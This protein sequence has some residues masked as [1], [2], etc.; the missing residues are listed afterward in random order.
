MK[1]SWVI[2]VVVGVLVIA[3]AGV[4]YAAFRVN[5]K[6]NEQD[7]A[8]EVVVASNKVDDELTKVWA[9]LDECDR[10]WDLAVQGSDTT[11][12]STTLLNNRADMELLADDVADIRNL[13]EQVREAYTAVCDELDTA[14]ETAIEQ[15]NASDPLCQASSVLIASVENESAGMDKVNASV[16]ACNADDWTGG[17]DQAT[18]A[19]AQFQAMR[20][21]YSQAFE[22]SGCPEVEAAY[23]YADA[24]LELARM[25]H[26][27]AVIGAK[28]G[29]N[30][31]NAQI[32]RTDAQVSVID[33]MSEL[34]VDAHVA[35]WL[36][37]D[38]VHGHFQALAADAKSLWRDA[39]DMVVKGDL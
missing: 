7:R 6:G 5:E 10:E 24:Y 27:L 35:V 18:A 16:T 32:D 14:L 31:Y 30:S 9:R 36:A 23:P 38:D 13:I 3:A 21:A 28:G 22:L 4:G 29:V 33:G 8:A 20:D 25:Q 12:L 15:A 37:A 39:Q 34:A 26:E 1:R 2:G 19:I 11:D 17:K